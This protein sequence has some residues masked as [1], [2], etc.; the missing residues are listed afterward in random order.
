MLYG[1]RG[2]LE[3]LDFPKLIPAP[4]TAPERAETGTQNHEGMMGAAAA[5]DFFASLAGTGGSRRERLAAAFAELHTRGA[6]PAAELWEGLS[7][8]EGVTLYGPTPGAPRTPTVSFTVSNV[9]S[10]VVAE[11]LAA[12]GIFASH[13]DFY[14]ATVIERLGLGDEG[15]VR[16]GCAC[17]TTAEEVGRLVAGVA[18]IARGD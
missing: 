17:Y 4:D 18:E 15:L 16:A 2:L 6:T 3:S 8:I 7:E 10:T 12:R 13:G 5:V 14:A 11:K 1:K 9:A